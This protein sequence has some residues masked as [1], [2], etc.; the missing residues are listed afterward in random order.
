MQ[1]KQH[2]LPLDYGGAEDTRANFFGWNEKLNCE[3]WIKED[4]KFWDGFK[5]ML[6]TKTDKIIFFLSLRT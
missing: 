4:E 5:G 2:H 6:K 1:I 3:N